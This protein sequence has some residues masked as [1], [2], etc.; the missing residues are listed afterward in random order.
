MVS[1]KETVNYAVRGLRYRKLRSVLTILGVVIGIAAIVILIA[2]AQG[3]DKAV[4]D[5]ITGMG[6]NFIQVMP[7]KSTGLTSFFSQSGAL[8]Q[9]DADSIRGLPGIE[10][11]TAIVTPGFATLTYRNSTLTSIIAG[12]EPDE[13]KNYYKK[14][15]MEAGEFLKDSDHNGIVFGNS[16]AKTGFK[17][18]VQVG[19]I[20][21]VNDVPFKVKGI[22]N[23]SA[24]VD[25][26]IYID[27]HA[28]KQFISDTEDENRIY[29][30]FIITKEGWEV[31]PIAKQIEKI[32]A[33]NHR[34]KIED[35][36]FQ[37]MTADSILESVGVIFGLLSVFL[38]MVAGIALLVG[39]I[40]IANSMF[41]S[42]L[43]RTREIGILKAVGASEGTITGM[44]LVEAAMLGAFGGIIG[45][46]FGFLVT[47]LLKAFGA[48]LSVSIELVVFSILI[49]L[50]VG[51]ISGYFPAR[52]AAQ[53]QPVEALR[54]E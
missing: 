23:P 43:E 50:I 16:I 19:K 54:Y 25:S 51:V 8:Y 18:E 14:F 12:I 49:S 41:T 10:G 32:I 48:P 13:V 45:V 6:T 33:N 26:D 2:L 46:A 15:G 37:L 1:L 24:G 3:L 39:S 47:E 11:V 27:V 29:S 5:E 9:K 35:K 7:G 44:F 40:G 42:V 36:D 22:I 28:A 31:A 38:G 34:V 21:Y 53:L 30:I 20:V 52:H 4:R 17:D